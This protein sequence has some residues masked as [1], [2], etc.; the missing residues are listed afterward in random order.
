[1]GAFED[2]VMK[3]TPIET[4]VQAMETELAELKQKVERLEEAIRQGWIPPR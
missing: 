3:I 1:M 4:R 2:E